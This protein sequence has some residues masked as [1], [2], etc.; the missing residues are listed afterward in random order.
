MSNVRIAALT[1]PAHAHVVKIGIVSVLLANV[2]LLSAA[3]AL[4]VAQTDSPRHRASSERRHETRMSR[5]AISSTIENQSPIVSTGFSTQKPAHSDP[6]DSG[7]EDVALASNAND[8]EEKENVPAKRRTPRSRI[9]PLTPIEPIKPKAPVV[10][11]AEASADVTPKSE[12]PKQEE[13]KADEPQSSSAQKAEPKPE[14]KP[15]PKP[16]PKPEPKPTPKPEPK[17]EP[18]PTVS[19]QEEETPP[20]PKQTAPAT[21][22]A[23]TAYDALVLSEKPTLFLAMNSGS[24]GSERDLSGNGNSGTYRGGT[25][26]KATLPNGDSAANFNGSGQYL[27]VPSDSSLSIPTTGKLTWEAWIRPDTLQFSEVSGDGYVDWMGKCQ[28]Y[29]PNCEWEARMY[30]T[31]TPE[32]RPN[33]L[34]AYVFNPSAGL[35]SGADWQPQDGLIKSGQWLHV[36]AEYDMSARPS[37]CSS[38]YP[39]TINIWVNGI[40]QNFDKHAPTGCMSQYKIKPKAGSSPLNIGTMSMDTWFEGA[41]GKVA[42]YDHLLSES[43][44]RSH[45]EAMTGKQPSGSCGSTCTLN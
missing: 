6:K 28:D 43:D 12:T 34:S 26:Q 19:Q 44:I 38:S 18:K 9:R 4:A 29:S 39:G 10:T 17:P 22:P 2:M 40:K 20:A 7:D 11:V 13:E 35:G 37:E 30:S 16:E 21:V 24:S 31:R 27:T 5:R 8:D 3:P 32:D 42:V 1:Q 25:P 14:S 36:V 33:R 41:V 45:Y 15:D 23:S